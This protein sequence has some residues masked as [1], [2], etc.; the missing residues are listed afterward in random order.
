VA[1]A[2]FVGLGGFVGALARYFLDRRVTQWTGGAL[3]WGTFVINVT[4]SFVVGL[5]FALII[6]RAVLSAQLRA[7]LMIG[8]VGAFTTFST[9]MLESWRM[10]EDGA[11]QLA[12]VNVGGSVV[13]GMIAVVAGVAVGRAV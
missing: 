2:F 6:E 1:G 7:P 11:W 8:F 5:L 12:L 9:L 3:P 10:I 4:G 13:I